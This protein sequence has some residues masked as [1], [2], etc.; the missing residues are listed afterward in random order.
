MNNSPKD[1]DLVSFVIND[2]N[3]INPAVRKVRKVW[4]KIIRNGLEL[5][6]NNVIAKKPYV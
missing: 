2:I 1:K 4:T 5:G 3:P 6:K